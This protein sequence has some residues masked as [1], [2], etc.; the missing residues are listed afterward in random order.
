MA[1]ALKDAKA[2]KKTKQKVQDKVAAPPLPPQEPAAVDP[3][4]PALSSSPPQVVTLPEPVEVIASNG[5]SHQDVPGMSM[6]LSPRKLA[7]M[8]A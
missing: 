1:K 5:E 6:R 3:P 8:D 7:K 2:N 4:E